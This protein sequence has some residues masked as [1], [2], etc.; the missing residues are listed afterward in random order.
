MPFG[1]IAWKSW[2]WLLSY[3]MAFCGG[4]SAKTQSKTNARSGTTTAE[5]KVDYYYLSYNMQH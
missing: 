1:T 2:R 4:P 3:T 5:N